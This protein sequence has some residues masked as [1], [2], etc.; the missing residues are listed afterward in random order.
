M[1]RRT[2]LASLN[3]ARPRAARKEPGSALTEAESRELSTRILG[4]IDADD[5]RVNLSSGR[6]GNTR[7]AVNRITT[8]GEVTGVTA[9]IRVRFGARSA[10]VSTNRFDDASLREAVGGAVRLARLAPEDPESLPEL[11]PASFGA[12]DGYAAA[13]AGLDAEQRA[14]VAADAI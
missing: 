1:D 9:T 14:R 4:M 12:G 7:Y 6:D 2:L 5:A 8:A 3:P 10:I 11:E 13:T